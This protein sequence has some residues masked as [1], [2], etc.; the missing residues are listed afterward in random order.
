MSSPMPSRPTTGDADLLTRA[1]ARDESAFQELIDRYHASMVRFAMAFVRDREVAEDVVQDTW[2]GA[3]R[4]IE[5][6][7][8]RSSLRTWLFGILTNIART[9]G[10]R[11]TRSVPFSALATEDDDEPA[12]DPSRFFASGDH[13]GAWASIPLDF[14]ALPEESLLSSETRA[15]IQRALETL[16]AAQR[17]VIEMRDIDGWPSADVCTALNITETNQRV[18]L[19]RAR[20]KVRQALETYLG[21]G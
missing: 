11:E 10:V 21:D 12:V 1:R 6:F 4:G 9:R 20:S 16:P 3:L 15:R 18:L 7:E 14:E 17:A 13:A 5:R 19:H 8:G 2:L